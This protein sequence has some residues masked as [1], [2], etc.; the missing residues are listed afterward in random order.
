MNFSERIAGILYMRDPGFLWRVI[1]WLLAPLGW[2]YGAAMRLR[3]ARYADG[4]A[5]AYQAPCPVI[6]VG[7]LTMGG[8][9]KTPVTIFLARALQQ[10][11]RR[12]AV[13]SRGYRGSLEGQTAVVS[14]GETPL[15]T[16]AQA[17]D[18]P[19]LLASAL[20]GVPV[21]IGAKRATAAQLA[22]EKFGCDALLCDD[23]FS[24]LALRRTVDVVLVH[25]RDGLGNGRC[26]PAGP[27]REPP[28]ALQRASV[29]ALNNTAGE[30]PRTETELRRAGYRGEILRLR[31]AGVVWRNR[32]TG[33]TV[34]PATLDD[35][36][37]VAFA[38][39]ARPPQVFQ[40]F[41][42]S[43]L[44][45]ARTMAYR[46][47]HAYTAADLTR[48]AKLAAQDGICY[49]ATTEKDAVKLP[50]A[51]PTGV[52]VL[53]ASLELAGEADS[54]TRLI[55]IVEERCWPNQPSS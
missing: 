12:V 35:P 10:R 33:A 14:A 44:H 18:E 20:P 16:A 41:A 37:V 21:V 43:G 2:L 38:A 48:L 27:L 32:Q 36:R 31:Y 1:G 39:T 5:P 23:A 49:L 8:T 7:N 26:T 19:V 9:G 47:H 55:D 40:T 25:G 4:R 22:A 52:T 6:S 30:D 3:E 34:D 15:L 42:D 28:T 17:G 45:L 51:P 50:S 13:L 29:I 46:D 24:H 54:L 53:V 11:G